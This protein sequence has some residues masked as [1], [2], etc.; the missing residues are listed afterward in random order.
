MGADAL[1]LGHRIFL[2]EF[3]PHIVTD[4]SFEIFKKNSSGPEKFQ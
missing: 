1:I 4:L 3:Y 2:Q